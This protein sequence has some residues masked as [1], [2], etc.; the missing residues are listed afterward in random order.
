M[1]GPQDEKWLLEDSK[2][3]L[4]IIESEDMSNVDNLIS[5]LNLLGGLNREYYLNENVSEVFRY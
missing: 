3:A 4:S 2:A 1:P 5:A